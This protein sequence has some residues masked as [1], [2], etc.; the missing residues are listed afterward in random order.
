[1]MGSSTAHRW[2]LTALVSLAAVG[3]AQAEPGD[4]IRAGDVTI[5]PSLD[6]GLSYRTNPLRV[7]A[8]PVDGVAFDLSP[9]VEMS[10]DTS[11]VD[12][13]LGGEY[14]L[15]KYF[16]ER[17]VKLD[18]FNQ[19]D[20]DASA[21]L[22]KEQALGFRVSDAIGF[23]SN[24]SGAL[25][26]SYHS[27][28]RNRL[29]G[30]VVVRPGATLDFSLGGFYNIDNY[31]VP[32][33][34]GQT[35]R[36]YNY[37]DSYGPTW[38]ATWAFF[39]R[40]AFVYEGSYDISRWG[41]NCIAT[42]NANQPLGATLAKPDSNSLKMQGGLRGRVTERLT[43]TAT[44]GYGVGQYDES[45]VASCGSINEALYAQDVSGIDHLLV[46]AQIQYEF[47]VGQRVR[48]GY[49]KD[50]LDSWFTNYTAF[51]ELYGE[52]DGRVGSRLGMAA[53][54]RMRFE[55]HYGQETRTDIRLQ[56]NGDLTYFFQDYA[57]LT[58]GV[59]W[60]QRATTAAQDASLEYDDVNVHLLG[61]FTY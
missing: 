52:L 29:N 27:Q 7:E 16:S 21:E 57:S 38:A 24:T 18:R 10:V 45:S 2:A 53:G 25:T 60:I 50:F 43:V 4:H 47:G 6:L 35:E 19:F 32:T 12:F 34:D 56:A 31:F 11:E 46:T 54:A 3:M 44:G 14:N 37:R 51:N 36:S 15:T 40:T 1:M 22:L 9:R 55:D 41:A 20:V 42:G 30:A 58:T 28:F 61:T 33:R 5:I 17:L 23:R 13:K 59:S 8:D 39:P 48:L 49:R 26:G